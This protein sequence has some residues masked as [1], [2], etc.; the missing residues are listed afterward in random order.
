MPATCTTLRG[1]TQALGLL[2][3]KPALAHPS[4]ALR[5]LQHA[6]RNSY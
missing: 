2:E 1:L 4:V 6:S 3:L 5:N